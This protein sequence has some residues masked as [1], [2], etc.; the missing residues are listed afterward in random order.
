[1]CTEYWQKPFKVHVVIFDTSH[2]KFNMLEELF[3]T[4]RFSELCGVI[5]FL[6]LEKS[7]NSQLK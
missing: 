7:L 5:D 4:E 2:E 1:M 6:V 3:L